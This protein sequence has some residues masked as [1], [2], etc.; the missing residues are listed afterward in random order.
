MLSNAVSSSWHSS[1]GPVTRTM[2][3]RG[4]T[5]SPSGHGVDIHVRTE[6]A[7]VVEKCRLKH[8]AAGRGLER[9]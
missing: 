8:R 3:S 2:G 5:S 6:V 9:S 1:D 4:K 7:Q